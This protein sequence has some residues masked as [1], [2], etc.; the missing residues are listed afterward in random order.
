VKKIIKL[1]KGLVESF[2]RLERKIKA[3][4]VQTD[5]KFSSALMVILCL[6]SIGCFILA[7]LVFGR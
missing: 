4:D 5:G 6:L 2:K 3:M 1:C 7:F